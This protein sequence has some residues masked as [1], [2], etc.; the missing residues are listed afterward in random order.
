MEADTAER[1]QTKIAENVIAGYQGGEEMPLG[2]Y[3]GL[4]GAYNAA[5]VAFLLATKRM[6]ACFPNGWMQRTFC[7]W[8]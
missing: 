4:V 7:F 1:Q 5:L 6:E 2:P 8:V 3:L